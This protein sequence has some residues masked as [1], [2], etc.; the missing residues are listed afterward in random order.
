MPP[1]DVGRPSPQFFTARSGLGSPAS[2]LDGA[3]VVIE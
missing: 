1:T 2:V 3:D